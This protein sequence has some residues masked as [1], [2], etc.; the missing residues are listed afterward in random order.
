[1]PLETIGLPRAKVL[2]HP[3]YG[4]IVAI[5]CLCGE[6]VPYP[7]LGGATNPV[8]CLNCGQHFHAVPPATLRQQVVV[9][10]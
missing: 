1:M 7:G 2:R 10:R 3:R 5:E 4:E 9:E 8:A 6:P